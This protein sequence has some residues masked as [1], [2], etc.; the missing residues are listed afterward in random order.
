M[1]FRAQLG[2]FAA[3]TF[4]SP[5]RSTLSTAAGNRKEEH[6]RAF[7]ETCLVSTEREAGGVMQK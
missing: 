4:P 7:M 5:L 6:L 1:V 3:V 2:E